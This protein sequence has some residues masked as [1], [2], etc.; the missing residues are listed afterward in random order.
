MFNSSGAV[1]GVLKEKSD[2]ED[3]L[4]KT[5]ESKIKDFVEDKSNQPNLNNDRESNFNLRDNDKQ[6]EV[7][8]SE[9][10]GYF[11][12]FIEELENRG[13][14]GLTSNSIKAINDMKMKMNLFTSEPKIPKIVHNKNVVGPETGAITKN[15][16]KQ[17]KYSSDNEEIKDKLNINTKV[18]EAKT[19]QIIRSKYK[20]KKNKHSSS[21]S[22]SES[23][24]TLE[25]SSQDETNSSQN[26][27]ESVC[28]KKNKRNKNKNR[29]SNRR[30]MLEKLDVRQLPKL[31]T[32]TEESGQNL[33]I[34]LDK[35]ERYCSENYKGDKDLWIGEL[36]RHL[37]GKI[38][39]T[40]LVLRD[41]SDS[42]RDV[43]HK[44]LK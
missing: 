4:L 23:D 12:K 21:S 2:S 16:I 22:T 42:Y 30:K 34:Y 38:L 37:K 43:K 40:F 28:I 25:S 6:E 32:F 29:V 39:D 31:E 7:F 26:S 3:N 24:D 15:K 1:G 35:F 9:T 10:C 13:T 44:L 5:N 19:S 14:V 11:N 20:L 18:V 33:G 27:D 41:V 8:I 17:D 36:E